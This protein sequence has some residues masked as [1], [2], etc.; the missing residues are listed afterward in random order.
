MRCEQSRL[1]GFLDCHSF[2]VN[3][4]THLLKVYH[5][6]STFL[7][8]HLA[9]VPPHRTQHFYTMTISV[10][11]LSAQVQSMNARLQALEHILSRVL[12][13]IPNPQLAID[14]RKSS[15]NEPIGNS[16]DAITSSNPTNPA[17]HVASPDVGP[18]INNVQSPA[19]H[20]QSVIS[21]IL[22]E[23]NVADQ[24]GESDIDGVQ[25]PVPHMEGTT[26]PTLRENNVTGRDVGSDQSVSKI[27]RRTYLRGWVGKPM[28]RKTKLR[29]S[30]VPTV[31]STEQ[32][33]R[34]ARF[35]V[36]QLGKCLA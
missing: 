9:T 33:D 17:P 6:T 5:S 11:Q 7:Q 30:A 29:W 3:N 24:D 15:A 36:R 10:H 13:S 28:K 26:S 18:S 19:H 21:P 12:P 31:P 23:N 25:T 2:F 35:R 27:T 4:Q 22:R 8:T 1:F 34:N 16:L 20:M 14:P 32:M